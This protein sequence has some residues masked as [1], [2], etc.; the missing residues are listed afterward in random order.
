MSGIARSN[1]P[2]SKPAAKKRK[3]DKRTLRTRWRLGD[4]F[5][6]LIHEKSI[7][8]VTVQDVLERARVGRS[9]FYLHFRDKND[10]LLC[11]LERF[12]EMMS[13]MLSTQNE[14]SQRVVGVAE[15]FEHIGG[16]QKLYRILGHAGRLND[17]YDLAH[18]Y[19]T[20]GI[21]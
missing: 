21:E 10:L 19:F 6:Q 1:T 3:P 12:L 13:T 20:R 18:A 14:K 2:Q 7:E 16:Q 8:D 4:A 11:Q 15:M 5:I 17:F 9:T